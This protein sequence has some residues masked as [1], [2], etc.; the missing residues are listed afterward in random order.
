MIHRE[1][2][3]GHQIKVYQNEKGAI[4]PEVLPARNDSIHK[5]NRVFLRGYCGE[6]KPRGRESLDDAPQAARDYVDD[7]MPDCSPA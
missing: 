5:G 3:K 4:F 1:I 6:D 2:R 7:Y